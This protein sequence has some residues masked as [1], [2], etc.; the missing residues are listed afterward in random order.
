MRKELEEKLIKR[1]PAWFGV[2]GDARPTLRPLRFQ[3]GDGWHEILW[4]LC[5]DLEPLVTELEQQTGERFEVVQVR[6]QLGT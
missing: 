3:C 1:F 6:A 2:N 5:V 4:R